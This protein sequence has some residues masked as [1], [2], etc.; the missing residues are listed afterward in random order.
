MFSPHTQNHDNY[1]KCQRWWLSGLLSSVPNMYQ[2]L[3]SSTINLLNVVCQPYLHKAGKTRNEMT[4]DAYRPHPSSSTY[5]SHPVLCREATARNAFHK[6]VKSKWKGRIVRHF[7]KN[8]HSRR[9][10]DTFQFMIWMNA[11]LQCNLVGGHQSTWA[12]NTSTKPGL[13]AQAPPS[14]SSWQSDGRPWLLL[15]G[16]VRLAESL[17]LPQNAF[18]EK[19]VIYWITSEQKDCVISCMHH[20]I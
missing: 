7:V 19:A 9:H 17:F 18:S 15:L 13:P 16:A 12:G 20:L 14:P 11:I 4:K 8:A 5:R 3:S 6:W 10:L 1:M 2:T